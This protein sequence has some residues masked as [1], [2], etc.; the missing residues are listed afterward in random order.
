MSTHRKVLAVCVNWNGQRV[1][2]ETLSALRQSHYASLEI[3]VVD[4]ASTDGSLALVPPSIR[5]LALDQNRGYAAA[6]N[7]AIRGSQES[8]DAGS[9]RNKGP[10]YFFLLN[11]LVMHLTPEKVTTS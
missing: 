2:A 5:V 3:V 4:N 1:L 9:G 7:A 10:D 11:N 6:L 8:V